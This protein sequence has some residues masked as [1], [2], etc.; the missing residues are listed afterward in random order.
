MSLCIAGLVGLAIQGAGAKPVM[1]YSEFEA[2]IQA[3]VEK[4]KVI[5]MVP[6]SSPRL[7]GVADSHVMERAKKW[8]AWRNLESG[9][10]NLLDDILDSHVVVVA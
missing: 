2:A 5:S 3:A 8:A 9:E 4:K 10:G 6:R 1:A 7:M